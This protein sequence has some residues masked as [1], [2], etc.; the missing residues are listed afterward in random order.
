MPTYVSELRRD[1]ETK[2]VKVEYM[3]NTLI[4]KIIIGSPAGSLKAIPDSRLALANM[5]DVFDSDGNPI[6]GIVDNNVREA[7]AA[8]SAIGDGS[9][10]MFNDNVGTAGYRGFKAKTILDKQTINGGTF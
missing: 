9:I 5:S 2:K 4:E 10:L 6:A 7:S 1:K 3:N 8:Y